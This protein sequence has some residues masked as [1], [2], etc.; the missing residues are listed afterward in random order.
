MTLSE[1]LES[2]FRG[3][4]R[5]RGAAYIQ[6]ERVSVI[7]V[8]ADHVFAVVRDGVEFQTQLSRDDGAIRMVCNCVGTSANPSGN[9]H[10]K[11]LWATVLAADAGSYVSG[12]TKPGYYPPFVVDD[13]APLSFGADSELWDE[14]EA[15]AFAS[16]G[17]STK[18][19]TVER[20]AARVEAAPRLKEWETRLSELRKEMQGEESSN[21][22][23][24]RE[25]QVFYEIDAKASN[26]AGL[27]VIQTSQRQRRANGEWG[28][29][30]PLKLR[31]GKFDEIDDDEDRR[32]LAHLVGGTPDR[33]AL[34][35]QVADNLAAF[36]YRVPH[37]LCQLLLPAIC[38][39]GRIRLLGDDERVTETL[40]WDEG[41]SWELCLAVEFQAEQQVWKLR[42]TLR[43]GDEKMAL[44]DPVLVVP[45]GLAITDTQV[46]PFQD[47]DA[48]PWVTLLRRS[49]DFQVAAGEEHAL[50]DRLLDMPAL[51]KLELPEEL[52][53]E[54]V[55]ITPQPILVVHAPAR[56][57]WHQDR[58]KAEIQFDYDGTP[59]R[60]TSSQWAI[61]Q[62][63]ANRCLVRDRAAEGLAW[64]Q[65]QDGGFRRLLDQR[66]GQHDVEIA[67]RDLAPAVRK[68]IA[69]GWQVRADGK[70]VRQPVD[71]KFQIKS[72][73]DWFELHASVDFGE[74]RVTFPEL[75]AALARG[76]GTIVLDDGSLGIL[77]EEWMERYGLL[78]GLGIA[79]GDHLRFT[80][81]QVGILDAL[82][83]TQQ[84][85]DYDARFLEVRDRLAKFD[86]IK[87]ESEPSSFH[88]ELRPYQRE[89]LGWLR[90]LEE[91]QFG[92]CLADDMGLGKT[93]Q[94]LAL[95]EGR[96]KR[97]KKR[98]ASLVVVPKSLM[99]NWRQEAEKFTPDIKVLE[100]SGLDRA[101]SRDDFGK[102]DLILTTY[103]TLRR[104]V[105]VL[106]D[107]VFDYVILDE[108][109]A[110]KNS[111]SQVAKAT[112][113]LQAR[114]RIGLSGTPI[115]N[116]LGDLCSIFEFLNPGM[117]GRSSAFKLHAADPEN[118]ETRRVLA[119]GLKPLILRRTKQSVASELPEKLEQ[120]IFCEMG[121][122]QQ[123]L[124]NELRAHYRD[125]LLGIIE[126]QG[127]AKSKMHVL[128]ALLRLRQ[129]ACHPALL[130]KTTGDESSAKLDVLIPHI[131][132]LIEEGHKTLVFSQFTS[133]LAIVKQHLDKKGIVYEYLDGQ[134]RDRKERV[135][136]FQTDK[137]CGVFLISLKAG[138]LGL[139]LTAADYVFILDPWWNPAVETQ[140]IDRA[141]RVGQ[142]RQVFAY[143]LICKGTVE[144]KIA[145]LQAQ[146]RELADAILEQNNSVLQD[147]TADDL[148]LLLS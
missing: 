39:T 57:R 145:E 64:S 104:D 96:R 32:I 137:D 115:E 86:G 13:D 84:S 28:K 11:H 128:E 78:A 122:D 80:N 79:E 116:H 120:T 102:Y 54:E 134:T 144:E 29:L 6:A 26:E 110:I 97:N 65:L 111:T 72:N 48:Y 112:R 71:L 77:P 7:R 139:N 16:S 121:D 52:R 93:I 33:A 108:A 17:R 90:F 70:Q 60:G 3:D 30:K 109:Q 20:E 124:Y 8:T 146:K 25:R 107:I 61:V 87:T 21:S 83:S 114:H 89:G 2:K 50:V 92:G 123:R 43:R 127:L 148:K 5:F 142:T 9:P 34:S 10:C 132:E 91:F 37:D 58:L 143:R 27:I 15:D 38:A 12:A 129:A 49:D 106:K 101:K 98:M 88:G 41:P 1:L 42:G 113:L 105:L 46:C 100:Y 62:R 138:G 47:F 44:R 147:L 81:V 126:D 59:V 76:D 135:Q 66:R 35:A 68:L 63:Q 136:R 119:D 95:L 53:L 45:G 22:A 19:R 69:A 51:P 118:T 74:A 85:V 24:G 67:A 23:A 99:F 133:M 125:S 31:P 94:M 55:V 131:E 36:R 117:L 82:L 103:G 140:A 4:I 18:M 141:H 40:S 130:N 14:E 73:I 56:S 75:L